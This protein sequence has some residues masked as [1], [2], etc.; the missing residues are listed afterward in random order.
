MKSMST[1]GMH[2]S[3][4]AGVSHDILYFVGTFSDEIE[5]FVR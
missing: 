2:A 3:E 4:P 1:K 5:Q